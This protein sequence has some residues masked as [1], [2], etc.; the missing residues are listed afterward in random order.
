MED[1]FRLFSR[2]EKNWNIFIGFKA[3]VDVFRQV[4]GTV[5]LHIN[6]AVK[7]DPALGAEWVA[8]AR[9]D[10]GPISSFTVAVLL[11]LA[12]IQ[13]FELQCLDI[14]KAAAVKSFQDCERCRYG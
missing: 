13:R 10:C 8:V 4:E 3:G 9:S 6:F 14:L 1:T 12:R 7:Q 5:V 2:F 11:S